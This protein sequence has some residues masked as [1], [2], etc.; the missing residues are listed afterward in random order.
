MTRG[1]LQRAALSI[2]RAGWHP[3]TG[4]EWTNHVGEQVR[5]D[6]LTPPMRLKLLEAGL[7]RQ[8][9]LRLGPK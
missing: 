4:A 5:I 2:Q 6:Q 8:H 3:V 9:E 7:V 1:P